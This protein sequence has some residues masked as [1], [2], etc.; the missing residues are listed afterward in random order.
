[1]EYNLQIQILPTVLPIL[2]LEMVLHG[3]QLYHGLYEEQVFVE[4]DVKM[5][6]LK[7]VLFVNQLILALPIYGILVIGVLV[8]QLVQ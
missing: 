2:K 1:M 8:L 3:L 6:I 4:Y 7:M 5:D